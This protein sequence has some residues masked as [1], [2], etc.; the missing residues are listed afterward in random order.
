MLGARPLLGRGFRAGRR[1]AGRRA[2]RGDQLRPLAGAGRRPASSAAPHA[3]RHAAHGGRRDAARTSG[4]RTR[5]CAS[6]SRSRS[7][8]RTAPATTRSSAASRPGVTL[9]ALT[10]HLAPHHRAPRRALRLPGQWDK[11]K[12]ATVTPLRETCSARCGPRCFATLAAMGLIL[13]IACAN[14][15]ALMLGQVEGAPRSSRCARRSAPSAGGSRSSS[16]SRRCS[17]GLAAAVV[18]AALAAGGFACSRRAAARRLGRGRGP[19]LDGVR[20]GARHRARG[21]RCSSSWCPVSSL[22]RGD[23]RGA[24]VTAAPAARGRGGRLE[25]GLVVAEVALAVLIASGAA[26]LVRSVT[27]LYAIDPGVAAGGVA[28][29]DVVAARRHDAEQRRALLN[30]AHRRA[31][32]AAGRRARRR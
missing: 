13:L 26:L 11:T 25:S 4:S 2:G 27:N 20:G 12:N 22:W 30:R 29:V 6:G 32:R 18:G 7:T 23:L 3:R 21:L 16:W 8:P 1:R 15:A 24:L 31:R 19:R 28:V 14:V 5:A 17:S 9:D 10:P